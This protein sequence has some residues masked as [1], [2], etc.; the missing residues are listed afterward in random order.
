MFDIDDAQYL[1]GEACLIGD[2]CLIYVL[3]NI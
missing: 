3:H 1:I 2:V